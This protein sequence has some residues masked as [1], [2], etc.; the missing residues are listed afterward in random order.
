MAAAPILLGVQVIEVVIENPRVAGT[1][2]RSRKAPDRSGL[3]VGYPVPSPLPPTTAMCP[4][5]WGRTMNRW[6]P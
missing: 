2:T 6:T 3:P 5:R 4:A 1:N